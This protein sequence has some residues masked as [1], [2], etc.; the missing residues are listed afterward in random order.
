[1]IEFALI[2]TLIKPLEP[3]EKY[4]ADFPNCSVASIYYESNYKNN[5]QYNG[6]RC[7]RKDLISEIDKQ[8]LSI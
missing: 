5:N 4:V 1:M 8:R 7:L 2:V 3:S 6:Y